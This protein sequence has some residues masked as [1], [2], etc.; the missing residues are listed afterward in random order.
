MAVC[1]EFCSAELERRLDG[2]ERFF[3]GSTLHGNLEEDGR[4]HGLHSCIE[5]YS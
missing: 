4:W 2:N 3:P 5:G 1:L